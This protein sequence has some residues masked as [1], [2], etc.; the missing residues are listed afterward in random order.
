M[1]KNA[2]SFP[3][4]ASDK[5]KILALLERLKSGNS[6]CNHNIDYSTTV[7]EQASEVYSDYEL[8][9]LSEIYSEGVTD[10]YDNS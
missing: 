7:V 9:F 4:T 8:E 2:R 5:A 1:R 6:Q 10:G 3:F